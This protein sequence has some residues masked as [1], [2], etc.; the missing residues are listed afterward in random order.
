MRQ[1][2]I[3]FMNS[4]EVCMLLHLIL[5]KFPSPDHRQHWVNMWRRTS[6]SFRLHYLHWL[7]PAHWHL[8]RD[9][10]HQNVIWSGSTAPVMPSRSRACHSVHTLPLG[11]LPIVNESWC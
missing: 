4:S 1:R 7:P 2:D 6:V 10:M 9:G 3:S 8:S 11:F 5:G